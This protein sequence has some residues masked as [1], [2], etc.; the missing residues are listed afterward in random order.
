[1]LAHK[2]GNSTIVWRDRW[3]SRRADSE[4]AG[5]IQNRDTARRLQTKP[6]VQPSSGQQ[7]NLVGSK[8]TP[9]MWTYVLSRRVAQIPLRGGKTCP[10]WLLIRG[11]KGWWGKGV[12]SSGFHFPSMLPT[13]H[14]LPTPQRSVHLY[15]QHF[16][17]VIQSQIKCALVP[18]NRKRS[19][20]PVK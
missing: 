11:Q 3:T 20:L 15:C 18:V 19:K 6:W 8:S 12:R 17:H 13:T 14:H 5:K 10:V 2:R 9:T 16:W 1:M 7:F 4:Q